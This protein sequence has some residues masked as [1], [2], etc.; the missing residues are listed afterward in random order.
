[1]TISVKWAKTPFYAFVLVLGIFW[2][3][4]GLA[5]AVLA[6]V[7]LGSRL[8][9]WGQ[10]YQGCLQQGA[11]ANAATLWRAARA[12]CCC[13]PWHWLDAAAAV[14]LGAMALLLW[15]MHGSLFWP[16]LLLGG[17]LAALASLDHHSGLLPDALT[18]PGWV[19]GCLLGGQPFVTA[20]VSS[21]AVWA[22]LSLAA[23][24][25][26]Q[27][28]LRDG[29]GGGDVKLLAMLSAWLGVLPTLSILW[30]ACVCALLVWILAGAWQGQRAYR[31][32]PYLALAAVPSLFF[33]QAWGTVML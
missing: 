21:V 9:V 3:F 1:M 13:Y 20:L 28:R 6:S 30:L 4:G 17:W 5:L 32:G 19:L 16:W 12:A 24:G 10:H 7:L 31:M 33:P 2:G 8:R 26:R 22:G 25:Y 15:Q 27:V 18:G 14:G 23:W 29:F 11:A